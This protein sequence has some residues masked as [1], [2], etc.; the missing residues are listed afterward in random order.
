MLTAPT[1]NAESPGVLV[2]IT[3]PRTGQLL[4]RLPGVWCAGC[5]D[6][7]LAGVGMDRHG[8]CASCAAAKETR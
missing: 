2:Q 7:V 5:G 4:Q 8:R 1:P 3:D 6:V